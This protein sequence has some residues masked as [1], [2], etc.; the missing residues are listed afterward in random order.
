[1]EFGAI[2]CKPKD[3]L[4]YKCKLKKNCSYY[5]SETK[6]RFNIFRSTLQRRKYKS[7]FRKYS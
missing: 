6:I 4:C 1:M 3:P 7:N 5:K 2:I